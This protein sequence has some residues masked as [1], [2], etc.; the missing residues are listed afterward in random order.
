VGFKGEASISTIVCK[1]ATIVAS[2]A[3][4]IVARVLSIIPTINL[5]T[6]AGWK[7]AAKE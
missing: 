3:I 2:R 7:D 5:A 1:G 6:C 4:G